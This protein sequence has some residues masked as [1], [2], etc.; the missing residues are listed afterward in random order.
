LIPLASGSTSVGIVTDASMHAFDEMNRFDRA[1][2]WL[3]AREPQCAAVVAAHREA[4]QDFRVMKDYSYSCEQVFSSD[5]WCLIGEAG[6][7]LDPLYSP[8]GDLLAISNG[9]TCDLIT[10]A[11]DGEDVEERAAIH[12]RF[13]LIMAN[14]WLSTYEHQY[15]LMDNAQIMIAKVIWDTAVYWSAPGLLYF[16]DKFRN[17]VDTP[18]IGINLLR[19]SFLSEHVQAFFRQWHAIEE[20]SASDAAV[21]FYDFDFMPR[22]HLGMRANLSDADLEVQFAA[23]IRFLE[24]LAGQL[25]VTVMESFADRLDRAGVREQLQRWQEDQALAE[26][27]AVYREDSQTNPVDSGWITMGQ[28]RCEA[29]EVVQ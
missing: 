27:I 7:A 12:S 4:V 25:V 23:N 13:F 22:L 5:R 1:L 24:Q 14:S 8:G 28:L 18:S 10:N 2:A 15:R 20:S 26:L 16:H 11:L 17:F 6:V 19:M 29:Q 3:E 9:L 21:R